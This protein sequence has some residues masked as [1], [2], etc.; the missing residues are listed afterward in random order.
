MK[1]TIKNM[2]LA[3]RDEIII[4]APFKGVNG[5]TYTMGTLLSYSNTQKAYI[6]RAE[7]TEAT[8]GEATAIL[9]ELWHADQDAPKNLNVIISGQVSQQFVSF[10]NGDLD[11]LHLFPN[12]KNNVFQE[13]KIHGIILINDKSWN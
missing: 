2:K 8:D 12:A 5:R 4:N 7:N 10:A 1:T 11:P 13:L 9:N 3:L 6:P